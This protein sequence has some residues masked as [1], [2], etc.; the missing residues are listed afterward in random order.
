MKVRNI[1]Q[2][3]LDAT[4]ERVGALID[5]LASKNDLLWPAR[6]WP[7]MRFDQP[8]GVGAKGGHG[9]IRY[10]VEEYLPGRSIVFRFTG[11]KGFDGI[12][13]FD[14]IDDPHKTVVLRHSILMRTKSL[15]LLSWP[16]LFR[17]LHDALIEDALAK[18]QMSLGMEPDIVPWPAWVRLLRW[19]VSAGKAQGQNKNWIVTQNS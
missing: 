18:A 19:L 14:V 6:V 5:T 7:R 9:P 17:P 10:Y 4:A 16:V 8:L 15:A 13:R 1:H 12:H 2:R 3:E 11:P